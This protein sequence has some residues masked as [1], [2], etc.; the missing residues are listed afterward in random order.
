[1]SVAHIWLHLTKLTQ[2]G[3]AECINSIPTINQFHSIPTV[4]SFSSYSTC[5]LQI[6]PLLSDL[7]IML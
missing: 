5:N 1:M 3:F 7:L 4:V 2:L 6:L